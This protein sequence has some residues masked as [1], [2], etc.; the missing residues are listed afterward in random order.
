MCQESRRE[1]LRRYR[2]SFGIARQPGQVFFDPDKD[3]LY[4]GPRDGFMASEA[5]LRT[6]LTLCCPEELRCIRKIALNDAL[7]W[8]YESSSRKSTFAF[9][10][11][12]HVAFPSP[13]RDGEHITARNHYCH[14][15]QQQE[16]QYHRPGGISA[17]GLA[18]ATIAMS[19]LV[20]TLQLLHTR[21]S[22]LREL[23]FVPRDEN[24][25]YS[26]DCCLVEPAMVQSRMVRQVREAMAI[27]FGDGPG[28]S[29]F[30]SSKQQQ[31]EVSLHTQGNDEENEAVFPWTWRVMTLSAVPDPPIYGR[32][33]LGWEEEE[34]EMEDEDHPRQ[35]WEGARQAV[36][37]HDGEKGVGGYLGGRAGR[38]RCKRKREM[39]PPA[40]TTTT[41]TTTGLLGVETMRTTSREEWEERG[42]EV[43]ALQDGI[44]T[45]F[46]KM[47]MGVCV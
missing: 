32:R 43:G 40:A 23:V 17:G 29:S 6:V 39:I 35:P 31:E 37:P 30:S 36:V 12:S 7:F 45:R 9:P 11:L 24:P 10:P 20:D 18:H 38:R 14:E 28:S 47:E 1:A 34:D 22:G 15:R 3:V 19:L 21:L 13:S 16:Q 4:F 46:M 26:G 2:L 33:V 5:Q 42:G 41:T 44:R 27:V 8:V 25:L